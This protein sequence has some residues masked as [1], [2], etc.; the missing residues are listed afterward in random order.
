MPDKAEIKE[1]I[2][3]VCGQQGRSAGVLIDKKRNNEEFRF[4]RWECNTPECFNNR[5]FIGD[6]VLPES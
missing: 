5:Q 6:E 3:H 1:S 2:C 4:R